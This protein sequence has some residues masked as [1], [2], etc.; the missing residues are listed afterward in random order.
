MGH[1]NVHV[2]AGANVATEAG[3]RWMYLTS[4][5]DTGEMIN[6][7]PGHKMASG[8][9]VSRCGRR[10]RIGTPLESGERWD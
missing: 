4:A 5:D 2:N 8:A 6:D 7:I 3:D 10:G 1:A 9:L